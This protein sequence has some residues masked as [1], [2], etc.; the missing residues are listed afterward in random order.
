MGIYEAHKTSRGMTPYLYSSIQKRA[1]FLLN[2]NIKIIG[3]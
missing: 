2:L 1:T 3:P